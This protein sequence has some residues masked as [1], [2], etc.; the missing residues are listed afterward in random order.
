VSQT[1]QD[2]K[3]EQT[4][5]MA[6]IRELD[7]VIDNAQAERQRLVQRE[8]ELKGIVAALEHVN[9]ESNGSE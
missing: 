4:Q 2:H 9:Q 6:R 1:L 3:N 5:T 8:Q 7:G